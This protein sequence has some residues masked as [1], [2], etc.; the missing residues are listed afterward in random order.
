MLLIVFLW[1]FLSLSLSLF[2]S[3]HFVLFRPRT[4]N[5]I[6]WYFVH[7]CHSMAHFF[8][9][10]CVCIK[11]IIWDWIVVGVSYYF[12]FCCCCSR[13]IVI[14]IS[15][16]W[17]KINIYGKKIWKFSKIKT[18]TLFCFCKLFALSRFLSL[19]N[20]DCL[21]RARECVSECVS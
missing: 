19:S 7:I 13:C 1:V 6:P 21:V 11:A 20:L 16:H 14:F 18:N 8:L 4:L 9:Y 17:C 5:W 3:L 10:I 15:H 12:C 2:L